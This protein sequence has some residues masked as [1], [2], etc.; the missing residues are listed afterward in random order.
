MVTISVHKW[1]PNKLTS[2]LPGVLSHA[3]YTLPSLGFFS[4]S[5]FSSLGFDAFF[6][7]RK[8]P[9][10]SSALYH[11]RACRHTVRAL[12]SKKHNTKILGILGAECNSV[13]QSSVTIGL[14]SGSEGTLST[15]C[16]PV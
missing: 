5:S 9:R 11:C 4:S 13:L 2:S 6:T 15:E 3:E 16:T 10:Y 7:S 12:T 14:I 1:T 8:F